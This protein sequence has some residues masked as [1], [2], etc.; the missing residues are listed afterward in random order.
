MCEHAIK[1]LPF[2]QWAGYS[3]GSVWN[4]R[5]RPKVGNK[6]A[7]FLKPHLEHRNQ[8]LAL[9]ASVSPCYVAYFILLN[10]AHVLP[11]R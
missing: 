9:S 2:S 7:A 5:A 1:S 11:E 3:F 8:E 4:L 10:S 6:A